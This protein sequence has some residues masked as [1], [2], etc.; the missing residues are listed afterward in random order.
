MKIFPLARRPRR[1]RATEPL[2]ELVRETRLVAANLIYPIFVTAGIGIRREIPSMPGI[3]QVSL[4]T[5]DQEVSDFVGLGGKS[6]I[7]FG[8]PASKDAL[9]SAAADPHGPVCAA[10]GQIKSRHPQLVVVADV[11]LCEY[12]SHGHC[13][14]VGEKGEILND[15][16][17]PLLAD[18][19]LAYAVAGADMI[20]TY[21]ARDAARL[22]AQTTHQ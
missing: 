16:S 9:G 6:V 1:L 2:R 12:T 10:I 17:L 22:L 19:A 15:D 11:C 21:F 4:D 13:G 18:A 5:L 7:L 3:F 20:I 8:I 14:V